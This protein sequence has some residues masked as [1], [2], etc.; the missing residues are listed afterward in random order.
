MSLDEELRAAFGQEAETCEVPLPYVEGLI[1]GGRARRRDRNVRRI[2]VAA[3]AAAVLVGAGVYGVA[4]VDP[5]APGTVTP[6]TSESEPDAVPP[7]YPDTD[8]SPIRPGT[9]RMFVG[10]DAAGVGIEADLTF[11]GPNWVSGDEPVV[12]EGGSW[13]GVGVYQPDALAG[14]APCSGAWKS[15]S[16][17]GTPQALARQLVRLP[18]STVVQPP[19]QTEAFGRDAIHLRLRIDDQC[20]PG[21][22]Y[23]VAIGSTVT[24]GI[25]YSHRPKEVLIDFWVVDL[26]GAPVVVD[27]WQQVDASIQLVGRA[28]EVRD[29]ISFVSGE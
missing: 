24:R 9:Y 27:M 26:H 4:Q 10:L 29:S 1:R 12:F 3:A 7:S 13:A 15:R 21:E 19:T 11:T 28:T 23:Q 17:G 16:A 25:T 5:V 8:R 22:W 18:Q 20:P 6:V 14:A 2:G